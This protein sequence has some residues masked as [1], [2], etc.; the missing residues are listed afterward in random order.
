MKLSASAI[1]VVQATAPVV[2]EHA[3]EITST[4]YATMFKRN[5]EV[6]TFFNPSHQV[7]GAQV[8]FVFPSL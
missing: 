5:P 8:R 1:R 2:A 3:L 7:S 6:M 4:F